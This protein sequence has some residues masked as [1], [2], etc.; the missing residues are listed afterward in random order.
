FDPALKR[1]LVDLSN[2][3]FA[4]MLWLAVP[5]VFLALW[6]SPRHQRWLF[7]SMFVSLLAFPLSLYGN[8]RF[9]VPLTPLGSI[10]VAATVVTVAGV[11]AGAA[12]RRRAPVRA[13]PSMSSG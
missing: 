7:G 11:V 1:R 10:G 13:A 2:S 12:G 9:H 5:G 6:R 3:F 8:P 4:A